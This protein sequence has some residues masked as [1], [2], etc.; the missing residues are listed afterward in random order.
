MLPGAEQAGLRLCSS[1]S[2][3][4]Y[5]SCTGVKCL[6]KYS[7]AKLILARGDNPGEEAILLELQK[8]VV[9]LGF[10]SSLPISPAISVM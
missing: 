7:I 2:K 3:S 9:R 10:P 4:R 8:S 5:L 6:G 1:G